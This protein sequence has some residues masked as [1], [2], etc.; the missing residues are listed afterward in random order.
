MQPPSAPEPGDVLVRTLSTDGSIA[1]RAMVA[2]GLVGK[3]A[4][5]HATAPTATAALGRTLMGAVLMAAEAGPDETL[6]IQLRGDGPLGAVT[7]IADSAG[8]VRG[9]VGDPA[10]DPP[11]RDGKLDVGR[12]VGRGL[13][14]VVR[15]HPS[16]HAP[17]SGIVPLVSGEVAEDLAG[18][19]LESEQKPSAVALGVFVGSDGSVEAAGGFLVQALPGASDEALA[20]LER[21][22]RGLESPTQMLRA[23]LD[24][25]GIVDRVL[26]GL[27]SRERHRSL[28]RFA[29]RCDRDR[30]LRAVTLLGRDEIRDISA[31]GEAVEVRCEFCAERY[32][33]HADDVGSLL[34]SG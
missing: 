3:A 21:N 13:L 23:G 2:T 25:D 31:R 1:V 14:A 5:R 16:W 20:L 18:Y 33:L 29:C 12:A 4:A 9:F 7:V 30:V 6:Q 28:P 11:S 27:G 10:A 26:S 8:G 17:Y 15:Y 22:V 32:V 24:A 34:P 19:L